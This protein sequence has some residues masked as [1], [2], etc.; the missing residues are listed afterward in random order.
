MSNQRSPRTRSS[1]RAPSAQSRRRAARTTPN[2][3]TT[4]CVVAC[5]CL[6]LVLAPAVA[7]G[8]DGS[9]ATRGPILDGSPRAQLELALSHIHKQ[10]DAD[11]LAEIDIDLVPALIDVAGD[12]EMGRLQRK[13]AMI[14][15]ADHPTPAVRS[16]V[17]RIIADEADG[18][19][20]VMGYAVKLANELASS[21]P[22]WAM[23]TLEPLIA[24]EDMVIREYTVYGLAA[25]RQFDATASD[26]QEAIMQLAIAERNP[27]VQAALRDIRAADSVDP[28]DHADALSRL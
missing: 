14:A 23:E 8:Q 4:L 17:A 24:H 28:S 22:E 20:T 5:A 13:R 15:L 18:D 26:A 2:T 7:T 21:D 27:G 6:A 16:F 25:L 19:V 12:S 11:R 9:D 10:P 1:R 3:L